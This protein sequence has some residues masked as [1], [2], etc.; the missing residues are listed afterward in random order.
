MAFVEVVQATAARL[1]I[2]PANINKLNQAL[3]TS[4]YS[5]FMPITPPRS[6]TGDL[7]AGYMDNEAVYSIINKIAD[8]ASS[9]PVALVDEEDNPIESHWVIDLLKQ[10]NEDSSFKDLLFNY[11]VYLLSIGNSFIYSPFL[12]NGSTTELWT[13]PSDLVNVISGPFYEPIVGYKFTEGNQE[14][15]FEKQSVLHGKLFN[16]RFLS[17]SWVYGLSPI[18]VAVEIITAMNQGN[19][20]MSAS[21]TNMGPPYIISSQ[22]PEGL[23]QQQQELLEDVYNKKYGD[24]QKA[25]KPMLTGTPVD[26]KMIGVSPVDLNLIQSSQHGLRVLS[27]VYGVPS[28]LFNDND[29]STY[30][31]VS[32]ARKDF[33]QYTIQPL[34]EAFALKLKQYLIPDEPLHFK[35]V[36]DDVEVLQEA[37][38]IKAQALESLWYLTPNQKLEILGLPVNDSPLMDEIYKPFGIEPLEAGMTEE[39]QQQ[40]EF[41]EN[42]KRSNGNPIRAKSVQ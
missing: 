1:G 38:Y 15:V 32:Q 7:M 4:F 26:V 18:Q 20:A 21:F 39:D 25:G 24:P 12:D 41:F 8:T 13:M 37:M 27:N 10:P 28:V 9:V 23:T 22:T 40:T 2:T 31:N 35:F 42:M 5:P 19:K 14:I 6:Y 36:Y 11:Y 3:Y 33:Y 34:N 29:N 17:G 16:P 30:N